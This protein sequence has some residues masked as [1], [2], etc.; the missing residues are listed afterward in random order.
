MEPIVKSFSIHS[1]DNIRVYSPGS[2]SKNVL[3]R[4]KF[5]DCF[6]L[7]VF[8]TGVMLLFHAGRTFLPLKYNCFGTCIVY[9][10]IYVLALIWFPPAYPQTSTH[11]CTSSGMMTLTRR[12][13]CVCACA[14]ARVCMCVCVCVWGGE[15][16]FTSV[17]NTG[18]L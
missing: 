5:M 16:V 1:K 12:C 4:R 11:T 8:S 13:M 17:I 10:F 6:S 9:F 7:Q 14:C 15:H 18:M 2:R 3:T